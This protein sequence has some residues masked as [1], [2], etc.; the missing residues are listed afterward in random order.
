MM[1]RYWLFFL[2]I[3]SQFQISG[4]ISSS[5][6]ILEINDG[7]N[8]YNK[9]KEDTVSTCSSV[10]ESA[11]SLTSR[12]GAKNSFINSLKLRSKKKQKDKIE[13]KW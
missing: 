7:R 8:S 3:L 13:L 2:I 9:N 11:K 4:G 1:L 5:E 10:L 12:K 6:P